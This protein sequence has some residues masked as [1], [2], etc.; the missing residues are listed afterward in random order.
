MI[1]IRAEIKRSP[2]GVNPTNNAKNAPH[3]DHG[4]ATVN[5]PYTREQAAFPTPSVRANKFW[6]A[7]SRMMKLTGIAI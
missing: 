1:A 5:R 4:L 2:T 3:G 6:P 7:V